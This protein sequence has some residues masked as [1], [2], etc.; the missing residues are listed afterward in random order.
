MNLRSSASVAALLCVGGCLLFALGWLLGGGLA[1]TRG[2][3]NRGLS[4]QTK[5]LQGEVAKLQK[6]VRALQVQQSRLSGELDDAQKSARDV[7]DLR[8]SVEGLKKD[9]A[10]VERE[11]IPNPLAG[12]VGAVRD[13][14]DK[15]KGAID[16]VTGASPSPSPT[17]G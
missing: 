15:M 17:P 9:L 7:R 12:P 16:A 11:R 1:L 10:R 2:E 5:G 6:Q 8:K 13:A 14:A 4:T 3:P